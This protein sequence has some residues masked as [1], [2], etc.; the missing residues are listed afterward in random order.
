MHWKQNKTDDNDNSWKVI[1]QERSEE[2][3]WD[4]VQIYSSINAQKLIYICKFH[5]SPNSNLTRSS[6]AD[7]SDHVDLCKQWTR[8]IL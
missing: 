7:D 3:D 8:Q 2:N 5:Q 6:L 4:E 1:N